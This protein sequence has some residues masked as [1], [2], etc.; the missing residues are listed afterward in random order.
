[1][2]VEAKPKLKS[3]VA[4]KQFPSIKAL[5]AYAKEGDD[6]EGWEDFCEAISNP[7]VVPPTNHIDGKALI[8]LIKQG[9]M[10]FIYS[11][12]DYFLEIDNDSIDCLAI[13]KLGDSGFQIDYIVTGADEGN[14]LVSQFSDELYNLDEAAKSGDIGNFVKWITMLD[15]TARVKPC[16][17][18]R[19]IAAS[20]DGTF[21][22]FE[23]L[24]TEHFEPKTEQT[25]TK[26][27][28]EKEMTKATIKATAVVVANKNKAAAITAARMTAG[29]VAMEQVTKLI[30]PKLP[31]MA[32]GY[33]ETPVGKLVMANLFN[34][35]ITQYLPDSIKAQL[36]ADV[37]LEGAM[38]EAMSSLKLEE[39]L[40][41]ILDSVDV[42]KL[43]GGE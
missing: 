38:M 25:Q 4:K 1:M 17:Q 20:E 10:L 35:A 26:G 40:N 32:R 30:K 14:E 23:G 22:S 24:S 12:S 11:S 5:A 9:H 29:K 43:T 39:Q 27:K 6:F 28:E 8:D 41:S 15:I 31:M 2:A 3:F 37:M 19:F 42:S 33:A 18:Y 7:Q 21:Y 34:F 16:Y 36:V 13:N